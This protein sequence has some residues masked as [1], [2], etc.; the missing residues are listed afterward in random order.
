MRADTPAPSL[1]DRAETLP[2]IF[3]VVK[4]V[5]RRHLRK[6]RTGLMLGLANLGG[7]PSGLVGGF[8]QVAGNMIVM[9]TLPFERIDATRPEL[10]KPFAFHILLHEY[11]HSI[12]YLTERETRPL[13]LEISRAAFGDEHAVTR[14]AEDWRPFW[15]D[16]VYPAYGWQPPGGF[17]LE[18][19]RGFDAAASPYIQ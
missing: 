14:L 10:R 5:V 2:E 4:T 13:V 19:V 1:L 8:F 12:G 17:D 6:E 7:G 16:L 9:N 11:I 3:G 15:D 18:V